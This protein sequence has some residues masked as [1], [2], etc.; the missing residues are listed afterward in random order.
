MA[1]PIIFFIVTSSIIG[2]LIYRIGSSKNEIISIEKQD[3]NE[4]QPEIPIVDIDFEQYNNNYLKNIF[5]STITNYDYS[6]DSMDS[7][8]QGIIIELE[9]NLY[10]SI[11]YNSTLDYFE[12]LD[13]D[14]RQFSLEYEFFNVS[15]D[16]SWKNLIGHQ[17]KNIEIKYNYQYHFKFVSD[18]L[19]KL[20][21]DTVFIS[22][23]EEKDPL[24][25]KLNFG[26]HWITI[27][28]SESQY[29]RIRG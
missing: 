12:I 19:F 13:L 23:T 1:L 26:M 4:S 2:Y 20:E 18:L 27:I 10:L 5:Y 8:D 15:K 11:V 3:E 21:T 22:F 29:K 25:E 7:I 28:F 6:I 14:I 24:L 16:D 17:I 9:N